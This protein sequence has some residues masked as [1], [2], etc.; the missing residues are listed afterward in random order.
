MGRIIIN[1]VDYYPHFPGGK[2]IATLRRK[3]GND[4]YAAYFLLMDLLADTE[5]HFV[6][7]TEPETVEDFAVECDIEQAELIAILDWLAN[8]GRIDSGLWARK[9]IWC[10]KFVDSL[11]PVYK[12]RKRELPTI[13]NIEITMVEKVITIVETPITIVGIPDNG[14]TTVEIPQSKVKQR[15]AKAE[16]RKE[17]GFSS[18]IQ[19]RNESSDLAI[20]FDPEAR[21]LEFCKAF[22]CPDIHGVQKELQNYVRTVTQFAMQHGDTYDSTAAGI[23]QRC[24]DYAKYKND[25]GETRHNPSTWLITGE[26]EKDWAQKPRPQKKGKGGYTQEESRTINEMAGLMTSGELDDYF[27]PQ[28]DE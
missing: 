26:F 15:E 9:I 20:G 17:K 6:N 3:F 4:G 24:L 19:V 12:N 10:Q 23:N 2:T 18:Q 27:K 5:G 1:K 14:I 7:F 25:S 8:R 11:E 16:E 13:A 28:S 22:P 21:W